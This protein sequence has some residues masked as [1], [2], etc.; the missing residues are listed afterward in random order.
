MVDLKLTSPPA[1][2]LLGLI[3]NTFLAKLSLSLLGILPPAVPTFATRAARSAIFKMLI[4]SVL[5]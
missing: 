3:Q 2:I 1:A 5:V 4:S